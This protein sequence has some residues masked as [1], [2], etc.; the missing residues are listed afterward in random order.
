MRIL[1]LLVL[2]F[3]RLLLPVLYQPSAHCLLAWLVLPS[4]LL[5]PLF[6]TLMHSIITRRLVA[7]LF[8]SRRLQRPFPK[9][10]LSMVAALAVLVV[11]MF[12]NVA[13]MCLSHT[14]HE[15]VFSLQ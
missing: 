6:V 7:Q 9:T 5:P 15:L 4:P 10:P 8:L 3:P 13:Q 2:R 14:T 1:A 11:H 12:T